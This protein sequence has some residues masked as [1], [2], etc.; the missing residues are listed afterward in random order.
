MGENEWQNVNSTNHE[1]PNRHSIRLRDYDYSAVGAYFVTTNI[2]QRGL[3]LGSIS[4][5]MMIQNQFGKIAN[6]YWQKLPAHYPNVK[7]DSF[8]IMP[9]HMH[10]IIWLDGGRGGSHIDARLRTDK[11]QTRPY[12]AIIGG[13]Y[14]LS[15]II[16]AFKSFSARQ[17]NRL[18]G[19]RGIPVWQRNYY[20]HII[21]NQAELGQIREYIAD[22]PLNWSLGKVDAGD[23]WV[24]KVL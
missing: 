19:I 8:V 10:G 9:D 5:G 2:Y 6:A 22:N 4:D 12:G 23:D 18:R 11:F 16:R 14:P 1:F 7:L 21:R 20:E 17:M 3:L 24:Q 15:E 13:K